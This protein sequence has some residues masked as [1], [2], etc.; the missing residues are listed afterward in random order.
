M[1]EEIAISEFVA[2]AVP[3]SRVLPNGVET[4]EPGPAIRDRS[5]LVMQRLEA[6][7]QTEVALYAWARSQLRDEGWRMIIAGRGSK[8]PDLLK[9]SA[10]LGLSETVEWLGFVDNPAALLSRA[11]LL[12]AP[13]P[14]EPFGLTVVEAMAHGMPV[15]AADGG[16]HRETVGPDGWLFPDGDVDGCTQ[17]LNDV[18]NRDLGAYGA[19][20]RTRQLE[21]FDLD[22][23]S[24]ELLKIYRE[25]LR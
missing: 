21:Y 18:V 17:L 24:D 3:A 19:F 22:T 12:L 15:I 8:Q 23:H 6:E 5:V 11:G 14:A 13:A 4:A 20:L 9:L 1:D 2:A 10:N 16:A 25:L 7:K